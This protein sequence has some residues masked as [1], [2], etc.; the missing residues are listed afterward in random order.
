MMMV[1]PSTQWCDGI[2]EM[3]MYDV[4]VYSEESSLSLCSMMMM[5]FSLNDHGGIAMRGCDHG[6]RHY[7]NGTK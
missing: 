3:M 7:S 4:V 1:D 5:Q 6:G 2:R